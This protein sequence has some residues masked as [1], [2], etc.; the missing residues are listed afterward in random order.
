MS[1]NHSSLPL[2][3]DLTEFP[4]SDPCDICSLDM[5]AFFVEFDIIDL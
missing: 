5:V 4:W 2:S 1:G 3:A